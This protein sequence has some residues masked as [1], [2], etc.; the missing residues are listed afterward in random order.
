MPWLKG[1]LWGGALG[2]IAAALLAGGM[3]AW[4]WA[5]NP[6]GIF[7]TPSGTHWGFVRDTFLSWFGPTAPSFA[8]TGAAV[9]LARL[10]WRAR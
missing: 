5:E 6:G 9:A 2:V 7:R 8:L 3:A 10:W 4:D 1:A